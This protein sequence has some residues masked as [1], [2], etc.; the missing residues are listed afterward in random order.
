MRGL[1][2]ATYCTL[3]RQ[4]SGNLG[5]H[6]KQHVF[7]Y[8]LWTIRALL[9]ILLGPPNHDSQNSPNETH[10]KSLNYGLWWDNIAMGFGPRGLVSFCEYGLFWALKEVFPKSIICW[11]GVSCQWNKFHVVWKICPQ[12][13]YINLKAIMENKVNLQLND[14]LNTNQIQMS[15]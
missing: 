10:A 9:N 3:T 7:L 12:Q 1:P 14:V 11:C 6:A 15:K 2:D 4:S 13:I 5:K 8:Q